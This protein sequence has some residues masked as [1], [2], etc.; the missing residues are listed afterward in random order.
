MDQLKNPQPAKAGQGIRNNSLGS[1]KPLRSPFERSNSLAPSNDWA[2]K[3]RG[4]S[5]E[6]MPTK[7]RVTAG[8]QSATLTPVSGISEDG[9]YALDDVKPTIYQ[10]RAGRTRAKVP[11]KEDETVGDASA[12]GNGVT[13]PDLSNGGSSSRR[14][15]RWRDLKATKKGAIMMETREGR[16]NLRHVMLHWRKAGDQGLLL[17]AKMP[18]AN[19]KSQIQSQ[20]Y[21]SWQ[22]S[23]IESMTLKRFEDSV[24]E[25]KAQGV[26]ESEIGLTRRLLKR[27]RLESERPFVGG[28][29]L[30]PRALRYD[31]LDSSR[32]SADKCCIFLAFPYFAVARERPRKAVEKYGEEHSTRSLLQSVYRLNDTKERDQSQSIRMLARKNLISCIEA[33]ESDISEISRHVKEELIYVPQLWALILGLDRLM[34]FGALSI[35][36]LQGRDIEVREEASPG[37]RKRCYLV[38]IRFRN[39]RR[40]EDLTYP[41][42][43]CA[44]WFGLVNKQQQIRGVLTKERETSDPK[45][46]KLQV[47]GQVIEA[48]TWTSIQR[49][50][51]SEVLDLWMETPKQKVPEVSVKS[52]EAAKFPGILD[53]KKSASD[54]TVNEAEAGSSGVASQEP[55]N[56]EQDES[57]TAAG[58]HDASPCKFERL[59]EIPI[60]SPFL[61]WRIIDETGDEDE[62]KID[63]KIDR[64]L[65]VIYR[66]LPATVDHRTDGFMKNDI[67]KSKSPSVRLPARRKKPSIGRKTSQDVLTELMQITAIKPKEVADLARDVNMLSSQILR[68]FISKEHE[69]QGDPMEIF[70]GAVYEVIS[71]VSGLCTKVFWGNAG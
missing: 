61:E 13:Q 65:H 17:N 57:V 5:P 48:R 68:C 3:D 54:Q 9:E 23:H 35:K 10:T 64:F 53:E 33:D 1:D 26:Q 56:Q 69:P 39:Q 66:A 8:N 24:I 25:T 59:E 19:V 7:E 63:E 36:S 46:Y 52:P 32:Y 28:N 37:T 14:R 41:I 31:S 11:D 15:S 60:V 44:C 58:Y 30:I 67:S 55:D 27:V 70:W 49:S 22:H 18:E 62:I 29:F 16:P 4:P 45:K 21:V 71:Q 2:Y 40:V 51:K 6:K 50:T 47:H 34:T 43:Q 42:E 38:R 20:N 12:L